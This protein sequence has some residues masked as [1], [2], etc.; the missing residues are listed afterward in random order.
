MA[1][2][3][4]SLYPT[5]TLDTWNE[6]RVDFAQT[7]TQGSEIDEVFY[8]FMQYLNFEEYEIPLDDD[9]DWW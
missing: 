9:G 7:A 6:W 4:H 8:D 2:I 3:R 1:N 5:A